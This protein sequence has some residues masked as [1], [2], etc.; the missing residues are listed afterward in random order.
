RTRGAD[1][2]QTPSPGA[3]SGSLEGGAS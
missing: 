2:L 3:V 1:G